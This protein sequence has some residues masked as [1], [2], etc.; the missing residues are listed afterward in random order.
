[1]DTKYARDVFKKGWYIN[2][3]YIIYAEKIE[4]PTEV[5]KLTKNTELNKCYVLHMI[6]GQIIILE[7][8]I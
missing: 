4:D 5:F 3:G 1:M 2:T 7:N 6:D 8:M